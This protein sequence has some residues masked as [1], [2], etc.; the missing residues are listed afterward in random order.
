MDSLKLL[1][2]WGWD[3]SVGYRSGHAGARAWR[4]LDQPRWTKEGR[5]IY[6]DCIIESAE[7]LEE[8]LVKVITRVKEIL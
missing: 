6:R 8:A 3:C 1:N 2:K 5:M 4:D 7:T